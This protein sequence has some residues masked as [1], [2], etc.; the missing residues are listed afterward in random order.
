M[1][2]E[3]VAMVCFK[4]YQHLATYFTKSSGV[5]REIYNRGDRCASTILLQRS[6]TWRFCARSQ[7]SDYA[8]Q[9]RDTDVESDLGLCGSEF[10]L[11][12]SDLGLYSQRSRP[13]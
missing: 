10:G 13:V 12:S 9:R 3:S 11:Y 1:I 6:N 8:S 7:Y 4:Y 5:S 2:S